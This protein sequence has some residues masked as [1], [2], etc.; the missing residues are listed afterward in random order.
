MIEL[1][2][3]NVRLVPIREA[4]EAYPDPLDRPDFKPCDHLAEA[5]SDRGDSQRSLQQA[6]FLKCW[7]PAS[8]GCRRHSPGFS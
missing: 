5:L 8:N 2:R 6:Q 4:S 7:K 1:L 3:S